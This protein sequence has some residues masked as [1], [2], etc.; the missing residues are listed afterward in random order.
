[1]NDLIQEIKKY[2][3]E[4]G[5]KE[6]VVNGRKVYKYKNGKYYAVSSDNTAYYLEYAENLEEAKKNMYGDMNSYNYELE[7]SEVIE[8]IKKDIRKYILNSKSNI[9]NDAES[10]ILRYVP[11]IM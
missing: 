7:N 5:F 4:N 9:K 6:I 3:I 11:K 2:F 1:M 10:A 8:E